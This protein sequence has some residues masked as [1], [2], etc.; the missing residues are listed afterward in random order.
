MRKILN[1]TLKE[2]GVNLSKR[3]DTVETN[4]EVFKK[5]TVIQLNYQDQEILNLKEQ[6]L[7]IQ[8]RLQTM[9]TPAQD[10][11]N[12]Q[13][14]QTIRPDTITCTGWGLDHEGE[15]ELPSV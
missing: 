11:R 5:E 7:M 6:V 15:P 13:Q 14:N 1:E 4:T 3:I 2:M 9:H 10:N 12:Y 8:E